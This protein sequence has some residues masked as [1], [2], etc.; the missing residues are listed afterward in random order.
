MIDADAGNQYTTWLSTDLRVF[1]V[2]D[3]TPMFGKTVSDFY[4]PGAVAAQYPV[5]ATAASAAATAYITDVLQRLTPTG[6]FGGDSF[7]ASLG[8]AEDAAGGELEYLQVNPR[9]NKAAFNFAICRVRIR[10]TTP[11]YP[12]PPFTTRT[13]NCRVFFRAF[14]A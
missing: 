7:D 5:T 10:G 1:S 14:Q 3:D 12:P 4:P 2:D 11:P 13:R 6:T 8:E 9:T